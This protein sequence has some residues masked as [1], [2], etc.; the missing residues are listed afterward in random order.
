MTE[1]NS[2]HLPKA[3]TLEELQKL[4]DVARA[5]QHYQQHRHPQHEKALTEALARI[6]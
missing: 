2:D 3:M 5:A 1:F 4:C 6:S